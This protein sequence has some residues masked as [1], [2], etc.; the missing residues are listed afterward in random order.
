MDN[1]KPSVSRTSSLDPNL[2]RRNIHASATHLSYSSGEGM[3]HVKKALC[4]TRPAPQPFAKAS[5]YDLAG[6]ADKMAQISAQNRNYMIEKCQEKDGCGD[7][8]CTL[9]RTSRAIRMREVIYKDKQL[10]DEIV[11]HTPVCETEWKTYHVFR[12][13]TVINI[14]EPKVCP[15]SLGDFKRV[16]C[17]PPL[18]NIKLADVD[19]ILRV[20]KPDDPFAE[21]RLHPNTWPMQKRMEYAKYLSE[22]PVEYRNRAPHYEFFYPEVKAVMPVSSHFDG[23]V[24]AYGVEAVPV[25]KTPANFWDALKLNFTLDLPVGGSSNLPQEPVG[26]PHGDQFSELGALIHEDEQQ[27]N[28]LI[29]RELALRDTWASKD[30]ANRSY[31]ENLEQ[32][33]KA[34]EQ[35]IQRLR[36]T[37]IPAPVVTAPVVT[38]P[39]HVSPVIPIQTAPIVD[40]PTG[41]ILM[42]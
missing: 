34:S 41:P 37:P 10:V 38:A 35:E 26:E 42:K 13:P 19:N 25:A 12:A 17:D 20:T 21:Y 1:I 14:G 8:G 22:I 15:T 16:A 40:L 11:I 30:A 39:V 32:K 36:L 24:E 28:K 9:E 33:L 27:H 6:L 18:L 3:H 29:Q 7:G 31:V 5:E 2:L 4:G 23:P